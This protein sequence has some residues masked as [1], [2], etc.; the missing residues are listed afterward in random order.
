MP[1]VAVA[2]RGAVVIGVIYDPHRDE[3]FTAQQGHGATLNGVPITVGTQAD[4]GEAIVAMGSP[5]APTS[6]AMSLR[7]LPVLMPHVRTIRMLGSAA[8]M[9]AWVANGRCTAYWEYDLSC[10]DL[11]AGVLLI[12]EA[13][14][15]VTDLTG[16]PYTLRTRK[17][18]ASNGPIHTAVLASLAKAEVV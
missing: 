8:L 6:L 15:T 14:G 16:R 1:S 12:Q 11:A 4:L 9:L 10:W 18:C 13:G 3:L 7:A 2:Y 17:L 5:P